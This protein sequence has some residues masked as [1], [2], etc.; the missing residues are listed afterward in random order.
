[1][2]FEYL[3]QNWMARVFSGKHCRQFF[4]I[5]IRKANGQVLSFA[6]IKGIKSLPFW[7]I[8]QAFHGWPLPE[9]RRRLTA[10][11]Y[12]KGEN[13]RN[14]D[15]DNMRY[16]H[17]FFHLYVILTTCEALPTDPHPQIK[18]NS[19][20]SED[21]PFSGLSCENMTQ[22]RDIDMSAPGPPQSSTEFANVDSMLLILGDCDT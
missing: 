13:R 20:P 15:R 5:Y 11:I 6:Q 12:R 3:L 14:S 19:I 9:F 7:W 22:F 8:L 21:E 2:N 17:R 18:G 16:C 4:L 10:V 1:M